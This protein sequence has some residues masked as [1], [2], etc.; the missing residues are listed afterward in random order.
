MKVE[1]THILMGVL[2]I[3]GVGMLYYIFAGR[4]VHNVGIVNVPVNPEQ[5]TSDV[6][7]LIDELNADEINQ[8]PITADEDDVSQATLN[9][10]NWKNQSTGDRIESSYA[11]GTRGNVAT[12]EWDDFYKTNSDLVDKSY[13]HNNDKFLPLDS[14]KGNYAGYAGAGQ[15]KQTPDDLFKVD[16]LLPQEV[17]PDWFEVM[18]E[19]IKVKNRHLVNVTRPVGV[20]TIGSSLKNASYDI[21]SSPPCPKFVVSPWM[22][23]SIEP[24]LNIKGLC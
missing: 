19:P 11:T 20:N 10:L 18:P 22:Q 1:N 16:K 13:I 24:D 3:I 14:T 7:T 4:P 2:V 5:N 15:T 12:A 9:K 23:S 21:R 6:N 17:N 8:F